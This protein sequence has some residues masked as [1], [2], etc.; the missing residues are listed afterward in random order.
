MAV[1]TDAACGACSGDQSCGY[2]HVYNLH[3]VPASCTQYRAVGLTSLRLA[4]S[5]RSEDDQVGKGSLDLK[6]CY[7]VGQQ[8][9]WSRI[10]TC[11]VPVDA[12]C[13][14]AF[15]E[16]NALL[17]AAR[18]DARSMS[19]AALL[20]SPTWVKGRLVAPSR[21][22]CGVVGGRFHIPQF[23]HLNAVPLQECSPPTTSSRPSPS[24]CGAWSTSTT[25]SAPSTSASGSKPVKAE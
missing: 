21:V 17:L 11:C 25:S 18:V 7:P 9:C 5:R 12:I 23:L 2:A 4:P 20:S 3:L 19:L 6:D 1:R 16:S 14:H 8:S 13:V 15:W 22:Q 10:S 24:G